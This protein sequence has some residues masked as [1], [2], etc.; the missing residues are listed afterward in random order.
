MI[1]KICLILFLFVLIAS[2]GKKGDPVYK[3]KKTKIF[4]INNSIMT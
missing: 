4:I 2:C 1:K 3:E